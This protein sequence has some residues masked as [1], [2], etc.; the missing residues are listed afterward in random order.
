M[1]KRILFFFLSLFLLCSPYCKAQTKGL[2]WTVYSSQQVLSIENTLRYRFYPAA[3]TSLVMNSKSNIENRLNF[4]QEAKNADLNVGLEVMSKRFMHTISSDYQTL[5][6]N[7]DLE[8]SAY[9][10][11]TAIL[12]YH[13]NYNP[14]DSL[15]TGIF[16]K[17]ILRNE[18]DRYV[19]GYSLSSVGYWFGSNASYSTNILNS[20]AG[21]A[22]NAESKK[23]NG[24]PLEQGNNQANAKSN[25]RFARNL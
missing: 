2:D 16:S 5:Y 13:P 6:D 9:V 25:E 19:S 18:Q 23:R 11:K 10:N 24:K 4:N 17:G 21:L 22:A 8:P 3:K 15:N 14:W 7:S 20:M 1:K 12:G